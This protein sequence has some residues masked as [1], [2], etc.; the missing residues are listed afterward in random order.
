MKYIKGAS[1]YAH[2]WGVYLLDTDEIN[3]PDQVLIS[4][5]DGIKKERAI[6]IYEQKLHPGH[7]G[8]VVEK[9]EGK[10]NKDNT[11]AKIKVY[12]D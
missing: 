7:F 9:R 12:T 8:G 11:Y 10:V 3:L 1:G 4:M 6:E 2:K 5:A